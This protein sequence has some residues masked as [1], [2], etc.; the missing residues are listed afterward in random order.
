[1]KKSGEMLQNLHS[2]AERISWSEIQNVDV[3]LKIE[4]LNH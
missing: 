4:K 1:M 3:W 2:I